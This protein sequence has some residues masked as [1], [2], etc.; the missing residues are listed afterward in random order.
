MSGGMSGSGD[1]P[2]RRIASTGDVTGAGL[3][4]GLPEFQWLTSEVEK[5][6]VEYLERAY[7][8]TRLLSLFHQKS[9]PV[10]T[11]KETAIGMHSHPNASLSVVYYLN[12][13]KKGEGGNL[14]FR[15]PNDMLISGHV[16]GEELHKNKRVSMNGIRPSKNLLVIFP[17]NL[18]HNVS[19]FKGEENRYSITYDIML[20][21]ARMVDPGSSENIVP[22]PSYWSPFGQQPSEEST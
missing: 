20:T 6:V 22:H 10:V 2:K 14:L 8:D 17:S 9:W 5:C 1:E 13:I 12:D 19:Q 3:I 21:A 11:R 4:S 15:N 7:M 18:Q 16:V